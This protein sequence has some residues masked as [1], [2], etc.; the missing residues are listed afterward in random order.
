MKQVRNFKTNNRM[1]K[2]FDHIQLHSFEE[3]IQAGVEG[4]ELV[5]VITYSNGETRWFM[6]KELFNAK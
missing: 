5:S 3:V 2:Q 6:K 4:Y 1:K